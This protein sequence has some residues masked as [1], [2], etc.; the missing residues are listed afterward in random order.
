M[1]WLFRKVIC[2][3]FRKIV[4]HV[5]DWLVLELDVRRGPSR[6]ARRRSGYDVAG[7][8]LYMDLPEAEL[9]SVARS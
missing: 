1:C 6:A 2:C 5:T 4:W 3:L 8:G 9:R 7:Q